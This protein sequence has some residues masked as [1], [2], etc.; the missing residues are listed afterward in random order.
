MAGGRRAAR[1][2]EQKWSD[3]CGGNLACDYR[4]LAAGAIHH[5]G[6]DTIRT[7]LMAAVSAMALM[8]SP[9]F[10]QQG[11]SPSASGSDASSGGSAPS[12]ET[13]SQQTKSPSSAQSQV[14][15]AKMLGKRV[16]LSQ[17][18]KDIGEI[19]D[20]IVVEGKVQDVVVEVK[21]LQDK[22]VLISYSE[23]SPDGDSYI[24]SM[25]E[26]QLQTAPAHQGGK[27][28]A[29]QGQPSS[30]ASQPQGQQKSQ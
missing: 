16:K 10:A 20:V 1:L 6:G 3:R 15:A 24:L 21:D 28:G 11:T 30:G 26:A 18:K 17:G 23:L 14:S 22:P 9:V 19:T 27:S 29:G 25:T 2:R 5:A 12:Q 4:I 7:M 13:K 8:A